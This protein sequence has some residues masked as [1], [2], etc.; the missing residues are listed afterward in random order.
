MF[1]LISVQKTGIIGFSRALAI[2][3]R[4]NN[5]QVNCIAPSAGTQLTQGVLSAEVVKSRKPEYVAPCIVLLSSHMAPATGQLF[6]VGCGWQGEIRYQRSDGVDFP[7]TEPLTPEKVLE[8]WNAITSFTPG[9]ASHPETTADS[10]QRVI[11]NIERSLGVSPQSSGT[12]R[13]LD[14]I[15][16][17]KM[18]ESEE[19]IMTFTDKETILYNLSLGATAAQ[20][21]LVFEQNESFHVIPTF[22]VIPGTSASRPFKLE[23]IV[24]N[25]SFK[26]LLHGEHF[27]EMRKYPIPTAGTFVS[28]CKLI[29]VLDKGKASVAILGTVTKDAKTGEEIFY[30]EF[31]LFLRGAGGFGGPAT[32]SDRSDASAVYTVPDRKP[33]YV[34]QEKTTAD[35]AALYR[36]NGDRNPLHIDPEVSKAAGFDA[37]ILHGLCTFGISGKHLTTAFG[38]IKNIKARFAGTVT[39]GQTVITEMWEDGNVVRFQARVGETGKLCIAGG[40]AKL[41]Q[42]PRTRL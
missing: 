18:L 14:A 19:S 40:G 16:R 1:W 17:A 31:S 6:E 8:K 4:K 32:R 39:P 21:P 5:I 11:A 41:L 28:R 3:G 7:L 20:L 36:L 2:E 29:D 10:R 38:P 33:D 25:Y 13:Y 12:K 24:P 30:N 23:D 15:E 9:K 37:P 35:Q 27:L 26:K 34:T 42:G 22:G